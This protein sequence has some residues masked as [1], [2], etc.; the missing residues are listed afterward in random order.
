MTNPNIEKYE[1][2]SKNQNSPF[3]RF[4]GQNRP[5]WEAIAVG[6]LLGFADANHAGNQEFVLPAYFV[7]GVVLGLRHAGRA[8]PCWPLLG[9]SLYAVHVV[10]I[11]C[12]RKPP[13]VEENYRFAEQCL[14]AIMPSGL[15]V[16]AGAGVRVTLAA[17]GEFR[18]KS[19]TPVRFL[20]K[21]TREIIIA[22]ACIGVGL[23]CLRQMMF[24]PTIYAAGYN[25]SQFHA[26]REGM[27][28]DQ[29]VSALGQPLQKRSS[30]DGS[31]TWEYSMQYT[32]T[33]NYER[34]WIMFGRGLVQGVVSDYWYD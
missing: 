27:T 18:R 19:G 8:F 25:E 22:V 12:G 16:M 14:W 13:Y 4:I 11:A 26:I 23:G 3:V 20:P 7:A 24:P 32:Y 21:T 5:A 33:S 2:I 30:A 9:V 17:C 6:L 34:R 10:A 31:E 15:G 1:E 28:T 29:V